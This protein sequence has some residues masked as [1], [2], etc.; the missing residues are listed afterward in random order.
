MTKFQW[1]DGNQGFYGY[2]RFDDY[3]VTSSGSTGMALAYDSAGVGPLDPGIHAA[4][5]VL[6]YANY[7]SYVVEE[8][9]D[10]GQEQVIGGTLAAIRY[11]DANNVL[12]LEVTRIGAPLPIFLASLDRGDAYGAWHLVTR[13]PGLQVGSGDASTLT[14]LATGDV[15][16]TGA[17]DDRVNALGGDDFIQDRGGADRYNGGKGYDTVSYG[18]WY[19]TPFAISHGIT[20]DLQ[21]GII[22]G[23]DG[24]QDTVIG[25]EAVNGTFLGDV[26]SGNVLSNNFIGFAGSDRIDGRGGFDRVNYGL[27][28]SQGGTD[29]IRCNLATGTVRDGFGYT[30]YLTSIEG[31]IGTAQRDIL[32]DDGFGNEFSGG[33]GNDT[34]RLGFGNDTARGGTGAD[35]FIFRSLNFGDD[36]IMD[37]LPA[38]GDT[39]QIEE[40]TA[41]GQLAIVDFMNGGQASVFIRCGFGTL[42]LL[43]ITSLD[44]S[45]AD[46][47]L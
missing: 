23:P 1:F 41:F 44:L 38:D 47:G 46:F 25:I 26:I 6:T 20:A 4:S 37:F 32:V 5:I 19:F 18:G 31:I 43:G 9:P 2:D 3:L 16:D 13:N 42:T 30:D 36:L 45:P 35:V 34:L 11:Y 12:L 7:K 27:D 33:G 24:M 22:T 39:I 8:G 40:V 29:G 15:I 14:H 21:V 17:V 28:Q 10:A